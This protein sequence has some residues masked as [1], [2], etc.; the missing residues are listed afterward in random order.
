LDRGVGE[1]L[2]GTNLGHVELLGL[3][4][5]DRETTQLLGRGLKA[6]ARPAREEN[7]GQPATGEDTQDRPG[8][9]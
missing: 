7:G 4:F 6:A 5:G 2:E 3:D 8:Q 9:I 1:A